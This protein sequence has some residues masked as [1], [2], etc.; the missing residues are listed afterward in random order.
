MFKKYAQ[1]YNDIYS[2]SKHIEESFYI[3]NKIKK[4]SP[5]AKT[6]LDLGCGTGR[7]ALKLAEMG[8]RVTG[9]DLSGEMLSVAKNE[10]FHMK[11]LLLPFLH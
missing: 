4:I 1:Y 11:Q 7:H 9:I 10:H 8:Y 6:I 2:E 3:N 5:H